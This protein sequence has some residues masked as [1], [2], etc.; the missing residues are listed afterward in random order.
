MLPLE[1]IS[2]N[3]CT[4]M[5]GRA[6]SLIRDAI[7]QSLGNPLTLQ[8]GQKCSYYK[9]VDRKKWNYALVDVAQVILQE[10]H[11]I[12]F[13]GHPLG[14]KVPPTLAFLGLVMELCRLESVEIPPVLHK[15]IKSVVNEANV[16][17]HCMPKLEGDRA[18]QPEAVAP[19]AGLVRY[20]EKLACM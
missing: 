6:V 3:F 8:E 14:T 4:L 7:N 10:M 17:R 11:A 9:M 12:V 2:Y 5:R 16:E 18:P 15:E 13:S 20:N 1:G 19:P